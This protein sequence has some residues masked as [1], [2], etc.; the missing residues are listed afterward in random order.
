MAA[1]IVEP[2]QE[3]SKKMAPCVES[4]RELQRCAARNG[5]PPNFAF[6][7]YVLAA[8]VMRSGT[9]SKLGSAQ[10]D[11][12]RIVA[13]KKQ[14]VYAIKGIVM[15]EIQRVHVAHLRLYAEEELEDTA[16]LKE[17]CQHAFAHGES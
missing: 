4:N 3:L 10:A 7:D 9:T 2:R 17:G 1:S 16:E 15:G 14:H 12:S 6:G 8:R 5:Q 13:A 11:P